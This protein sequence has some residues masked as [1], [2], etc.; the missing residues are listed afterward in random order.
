L[1]F[2]PPQVKFILP[3]MGF[4]KN[5]FTDIFCDCQLKTNKDYDGI[6]IKEKGRQNKEYERVRREK[7]DVRR[8]KVGQGFSLAFSEEVNGL[9]RP[10]SARLAMTKRQI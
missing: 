6:R 8:K 7:E 4:L 2:A 3:V 1:I 9:L 10:P 5:Y